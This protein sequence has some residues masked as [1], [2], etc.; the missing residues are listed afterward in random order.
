MIKNTVNTFQAC[1]P[2]VM[3]SACVKWA[4]EQVDAFNDILLR[5]LSNTNPGEK[6]WIETMN[7]ARDHVKMLSEV[8]LDFDHLIGKKKVVEPVVQSTLELPK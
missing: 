4:K 2:K 6:T 5:Q 1:F 8:G 3:T 7:Q